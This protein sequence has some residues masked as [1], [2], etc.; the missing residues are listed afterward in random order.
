MKSRILYLTAAAGFVVGA[1]MEF[2]PPRNVTAGVL[3]AVAGAIFLLLG[4]IAK[5]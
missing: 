5:P 3:D 2:L 4:I 1:V